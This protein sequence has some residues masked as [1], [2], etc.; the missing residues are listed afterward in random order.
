MVSKGSITSHNEIFEKILSK[1]DKERFALKLS[2]REFTK[3]N[4][5]WL[6]FKI[7]NSRIRPKDRTSDGSITTKISETAQIFYGY[8]ESHV[9]IYS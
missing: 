1:L 9:Q 2:K 8:I 5:T 4:L 7:D 3:I 6:G